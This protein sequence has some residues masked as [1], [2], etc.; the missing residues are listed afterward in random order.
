MVPAKT[1]RRRTAVSEYTNLN[2]ILVV[3]VGWLYWP[4]HAHELT[5]TGR[6]HWNK[7]KQWALNYELMKVRGSLP[8]GTQ[9]VSYGMP[10]AF[11]IQ[12][13]SAFVETTTS[14]TNDQLGECTSQVTGFQVIKTIA[15]HT[16]KIIVCLFSKQQ[17]K[18]TTVKTQDPEGIFGLKQ[19]DIHCQGQT[20]KPL[21]GW[22]QTNTRPI[23][24]TLASEKPLALGST[25]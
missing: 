10:H 24:T 25:W 12:F 7:H 20:L 11:L 22:T 23:M 5:N 9:A 17:S 6:Q 19:T 18:K 1:R 2:A 4:T 21:L 14:R 15:K 8:Q 3:V 16:K 13:C